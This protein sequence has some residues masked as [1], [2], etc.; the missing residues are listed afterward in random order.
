MYLRTDVYGLQKYLSECLALSQ[1]QLKVQSTHL[2]LF[3]RFCRLGIDA[4]FASRECPTAVNKS[5]SSSPTVFKVHTAHSL[6]KA[7][8][9]EGRE[10]LIVSLDE[11]EIAFLPS[12]W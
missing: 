11:L 5:L 9:R 6:K 3:T 10:K 1:L 7:Q 8:A 2:L 4:L 12:V